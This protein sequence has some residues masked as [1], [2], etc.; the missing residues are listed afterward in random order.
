M[1]N[2]FKRKNP[3]FQK[4]QDFFSEINIQC[5]LR[6][7]D[8][9]LWSQVYNRL[10]YKPVDYLTSNIDYQ[11]EYVSQNY[12]E[13]SDLS[14]IMIVDNN[15]ISIWPLSIAS[16]GKDYFLSSQGSNILPPIFISDCP[17]KIVKKS[18]SATF[19]LV[20]NLCEKFKINT[21]TSSSIFHNNQFIQNWHLLCIEKGAKSQVECNLF[22][23]L[24]LPLK[25]IK[26]KFRKS[27]RPL[28]GQGMRLWN[29]KVHDHFIE[30]ETW[31]TFKK[32]HFDVS[33]RLTRSEESWNI[34]FNNIKIGNAFLVSVHDDKNIL[35][36]GGY[37]TF[38]PDEGIYSVGVFNRD[39][40]DKPLGHI[41]QFKAIEELKKRKV[42]WYEIG[43]NIFESDIPK[44]SSKELSISHFKKGFTSLIFPEFILKN[45]IK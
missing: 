11:S 12:D 2:D 34:Q 39:L 31:K 16:M 3:A 18:L 43:R 32:L 10:I 42:Q 23:D 33:G 35:V 8:I 41:V 27:Y 6:R 36:G 19:D 37:F 22:I 4:I 26:S 20:N 17:S 38:S 45:H 14:C 24:S 7:D 5:V 30:H 15:P 28:I 44:P 1:S 29:V 21:W 9:E 25:E 13:F 40:F